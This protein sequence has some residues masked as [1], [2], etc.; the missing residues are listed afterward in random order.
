MKIVYPAGVALSNR[1]LFRAMAVSIY[2]TY[3]TY[4]TYKKALVH[5]LIYGLGRKKSSQ[6]IRS[7]RALGQTGMSVPRSVCYLKENVFVSV[8]Q[9]FLSVQ[10]VH[11]E[12]KSSANDCD[13]S[14]F[15]HSNLYEIFKSV[16]TA[17]LK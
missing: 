7:S 17:T 1:I 14:D 8:G 10:N 9:T 3:G 5:T 16:L 4:R 13:H 6:K 11:V 2:G 12:I 15:L